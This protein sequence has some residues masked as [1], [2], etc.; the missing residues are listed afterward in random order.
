M[1]SRTVEIRFDEKFQN[2]VTDSLKDVHDAIGYLATWAIH[3]ADRY[4]GT[5]TIV[6]DQHG[7]LHANYRN[8]EG[9]LSYSMLGQR[10]TDGSYT[11][12]S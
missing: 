7:D 5:V 2:I 4:A 1:H 10:D 3:S 6:G 9:E 12:H 8:A 11:F